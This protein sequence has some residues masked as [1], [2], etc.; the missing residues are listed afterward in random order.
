MAELLAELAAGGVGV[1]FSSHQLDLV[2]DVCEDVV[3]INQGR[4]VLAG[5][6]A[7]LKKRPVAAISRSPSMGGPG[8]PIW[9]ESTSFPDRPPS[10]LSGRH[11]RPAR[12]GTRQGASAGRGDDVTVEPPSLTDL[13][14]ESGGDHEGAPPDVRDR[15]EGLHPAGQE[16]SLPG[17]DRGGGS[18]GL[19]DRPAPGE[20]HER[21]DRPRRSVLSE[22][23]NEGSDGRPLG[24]D[25]FGLEVR[26][27]PP[28]ARRR[29]SRPP[30]WGVRVV[31]TEDRELVWLD[32]SNQT[33]AAIVGPAQQATERDQR[34]P[35]WA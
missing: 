11:L 10:R 25:G 1:V 34:S 16:Q 30:R 33:L 28:V 31:V 20:R 17:L 22:S 12:R 21:S 32:E 3:I 15:P 29:R 6:V 5:A 26:F 2:E 9:T 14:R 24:R 19:D 13:F 35:S 27:T 18:A 23:Y 8:S 7:A 4:V